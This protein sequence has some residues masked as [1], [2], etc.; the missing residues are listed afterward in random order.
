MEHFKQIFTRRAEEYHRMI[1][2]EDTDGNLLPA[3]L[4]VDPLSGKRVLD[5]G[6]GTGRI[7]FLIGSVNIQT[8]GTGIY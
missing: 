6:S 3:L 5:L 1:I 8:H 7:F 4:R 2:P